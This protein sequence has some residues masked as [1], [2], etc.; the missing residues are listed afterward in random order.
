M[1]SFNDLE[2][3]DDQDAER[4]SQERERDDWNRSSN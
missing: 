3:F 1:G 4:N 2:K